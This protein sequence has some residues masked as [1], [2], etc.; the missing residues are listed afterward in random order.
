MIRDFQYSPAPRGFTY[1]QRQER[2]EK[3][4]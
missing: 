3:L 1:V 4:G 2:T